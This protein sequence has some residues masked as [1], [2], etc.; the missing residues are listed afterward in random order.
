MTPHRTAARREELQR[1]FDSVDDILHLLGEQVR[2]A[3]LTAHVAT[4]RHG[5]NETRQGFRHNDEKA[6]RSSSQG[7]K[8]AVHEVRPV[9]ARLHARD[10]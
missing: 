3:D 6:V 2:G 7:L 9:P 1:Y 5:T 10:P 8:K 4:S